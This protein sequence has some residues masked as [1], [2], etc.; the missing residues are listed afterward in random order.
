M[1]EQRS[2]VFKAAYWSFEETPD[3]ELY[4]HIGGLTSKMESVQVRVHNFTPYVY[5]ELPARVNW[6]KDRGNKLFEYLTKRLKTEGPLQHKLLMKKKLHYL[7]DTMCMFLTF[8]TANLTRK[9]SRMCAT[10]RDM[11]IPGLGTFGPGDFKVHEDN[12]DP[13][14]KFT[15]TRKL[16]LAGW[17][18]VKESTELL[19]EG[20]DT[21]DQKFTSC[22]IDMEADWNDVNPV[23]LKDKVF[24][25]PKYCSF[26]IEC[27]SFNP[28][29]K[30]P[31]PSTRENVVFQISM[32]FGR[33][34]GGHDV[35]RKV[36]LTLFDPLDI[37]GVDMIRCPG[38]KD[39]LLEFTRVVNEEDPDIFIGYNIMKFDWNY[40]IERVELLGI[41]TAFTKMSRLLGE[42]A[43]VKTQKWTSSAYGEQEFRYLDCHGRTNV[44]VLLEVERNFKLPKYSLDLVSERFLG[45]NKEDISARQLFMLYQLTDEIYPS[46]RELEMVE[47][48]QLAEIKKRVMD[49]FPLRKTHGVVRELRKEI[50]ECDGGEIKDLVRKALHLTG[51]YCVKDTI[52]PV[53]LVEKLNL[54]IVM[55]EMSNVMNVP[56]SYLHTRGQQIRVLAQIYRE[57]IPNNIFIPKNTK[58]DDTRFQGALVAEAHPGDYDNVATLDFASLYPSIIIDKNICYTTI[59]EDDDPTPDEEC[60]VI[61]WEDHVGCPCDP[62]RRKVAKEKVLCQKCRYR[63]RRVRYV[64]GVGGE[65]ERKHEGLLPRLERRMLSERKAVKKEMSKMEAKLKMQR[66]KADE[67][68]LQFYRKMGWEIIEAGSMGKHEDMMLEVCVNVLNA[69]QLALKVAGNSMYGSLG[70]KN[71]FIPLIGGAASVTAMGR[72]LITMSIEK[73]RK[74]WKNAKIVYGDTDSAMISF[75]GENLK[76]SFELSKEA[77]RVV[78]HYLKT[79]SMGVDE[80]YTVMLRD[81]TEKRLEQ[82]KQKDVDLIENEEHKVRAL[83]YL[84]SPIDLEFENMYGRFLLLTK[85]R[86]IAHSVNQKGEIV[87]TTKKGVVLARRDNCQYLRDTYKLIV[88]KILDS[89]GES[90]VMKVLY[91]RIDALFTRRIP[92]T[93][94]II[95]MGV[96]SIV[97]YAK[98]KT[99]SSG[100]TLFL[101]ANG[102]P[103]EDITGPLD[104]RLVY[105]N[106]PQ[107]LLALK[108]IQRGD[109]IPPNTRLEFLYLRDRGDHVSDH[110]GEKAEDYTFYKENKAIYGFAPDYLHYIEKQ[111][112][113]PVEELLRVKYPKDPIPYIVWEDRVKELIGTLDQLQTFRVAN[114]QVHRREVADT[115]Y[116]KKGLLAKAAYIVDSSRKNEVNEISYEHNKEL[117]DACKNLLARD[118]LD[119]VYKAFGLTKRPRRKPTQIGEKL[120]LDYDVMLMRDIGR[121]KRGTLGKVA[122]L[123]E[124]NT[125]L[126]TKYIYD[127]VVH[128]QEG[129]ELL[130]SVPRVAFTTYYIRDDN[131]MKSVLQARSKYREVVVH[132]NQLGNP[133]VFE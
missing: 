71:G 33:I 81:G 108:M 50:L 64:F 101:D 15:A 87:S 74:E 49:I 7:R 113:K 107:C 16:S 66:G 31:N 3:H 133:L 2:V 112:S 88:D 19:E 102:D 78:T 59:L 118:V 80:N 114:I 11:H 86:Y 132:I 10:S 83:E 30:L 43:E 77:S 124:D 122:A 6:N 40:M 68:D 46:I 109:D 104:P 61:E 5:L 60:H 75:P 22:D 82:V 26:D 76:R 126:K 37:E 100:V 91:D 103:I 127:L 129:Q 99:L 79:Y 70:V 63:F 17:I 55:E 65:V 123:R 67:G 69:Q 94:L 116:K 52:L 45:E 13:V 20:L 97:E 41:R 47:E 23:K 12:I 62:K 105:P 21:E 4:I 27:Y 34:G 39:L 117:V 28:N 85:K 57:T 115:E 90:E 119:R 36:L 58:N 35:E 53:R 95:Y 56:V 54:W 89:E 25:F 44:D 111:L 96:K 121:F 29:S 120:P 110:Q 93:H 9:F 84:E 130:I 1:T 106:I 24:T 32:V 48:D 128:D 18:K 98:K 14:I 38:E 131:F 72:Q 8:R 51:V 42:K 125:G 73:V 92:D